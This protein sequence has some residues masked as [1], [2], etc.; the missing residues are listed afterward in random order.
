MTEYRT[1]MGYGRAEIEEKRSIFIGSAD[2]VTTEDE[3]I[4]FINRIRSEFPDAR[5][6]VYAYLLNEGAKTRYS[7]DREPQGTAGIPVLEVLRKNECRDAVIVVT[8]YFG[9]ILLGAGGLARAY[10]EAAAAALHAAGHVLRTPCEEYSFTCPYADYEKC[11]AL[12]ETLGVMLGEPEF[13]ADVL[14]RYTVRASAAG[15]I[16]DKIF[17]STYGRISPKKCGEGWEKIKI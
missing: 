14:V 12:L 9:G 6:N 10:T 1:I 17:D 11:R 2:F 8:R 15:A 4:A 3:A 7:D 13:G 5:H 16:A